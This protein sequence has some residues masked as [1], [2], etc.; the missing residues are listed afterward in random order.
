MRKTIATLAAVV[1]GA[2]AFGA[3]AGPA[4]ADVPNPILTS[5]LPPMSGAGSPYPS[6][7]TTWKQCQTPQS[8]GVY[9]QYGASGYFIDG[10]TVKESCNRYNRNGCLVRSYTT[11]NLGTFRGDGVSQNARLRAFNSYDQLVGWS[12]RSCGRVSDTCSTADYRYLN[13]GESASIQC[14]GVRAWTQI[15]NSASNTC[16]IEMTYR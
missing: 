13:A 10:C 6:G 2:A 5:S 8:A 14:N 7:I 12:D 16:R 11:I 3:T 9:G 1:A 15:A 4:A